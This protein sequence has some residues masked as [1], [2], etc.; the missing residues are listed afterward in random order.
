M[1]NND[2]LSPSELEVLQHEAR[3]WNAT[4]HKKRSTTSSST[5]SAPH[6]EPPRLAIDLESLPTLI[7]NYCI[8]QVRVMIAVGAVIGFIAAAVVIIVGVIGAIIAAWSDPM[9]VEAPTILISA[10]IAGISIAP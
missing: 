10:I 5:L 6:A 8:N 3:K 7:I 1:D 2:S 4:P 9:A